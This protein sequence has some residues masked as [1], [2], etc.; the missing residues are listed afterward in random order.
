VPAALVLPPVHQSQ[1]SSRAAAHQ[2]CLLPLVLLG[3]QQLLLLL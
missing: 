3:L 2:Q 1:Q